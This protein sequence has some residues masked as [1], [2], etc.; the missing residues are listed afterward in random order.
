MAW[1][2]SNTHPRDQLRP[3]PKSASRHYRRSNHRMTWEYSERA[4][5]E[6]AAAPHRPPL[7]LCAAFAATSAATAATQ[8]EQL[9]CSE[10]CAF[11]SDLGFVDPASPPCGPSSALIAG[12]AGAGSTGN[13][14][15]RTRR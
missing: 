13:S 4:E 1:L 11:S 3:Y 2:Q 14:G 10:V 15:R 12:A 6:E 8:R 5:A 9:Y 7:A